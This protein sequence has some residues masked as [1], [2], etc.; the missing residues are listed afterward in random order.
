[1]KINIENFDYVAI[2]SHTMRHE[3][4]CA[5]EAKGRVTTM[6]MEKYSCMILKQHFLSWQSSSHAYVIYR[7][8]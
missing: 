4:I 5:F 2:V 6:D 7:H 8:L 1:M 3:W